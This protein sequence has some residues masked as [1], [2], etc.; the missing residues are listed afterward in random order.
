MAQ[1]IMNEV[2]QLNQLS[3]L[4]A[5]KSMMREIE[6]GVQDDKYD[7]LVSSIQ[8]IQKEVNE[9]V[10]KLVHTNSSLDSLKKVKLIIFHPC[11]CP[12]NFMFI[13]D[14]KFLTMLK[15]IWS[16]IF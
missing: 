8:I 13:C 7:R 14:K 6:E 10:Q 11:N 9:S 12:H 16:Y 1:K 3:T 5:S 15:R 4:K 2:E